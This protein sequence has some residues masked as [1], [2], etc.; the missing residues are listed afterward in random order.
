MKFSTIL[1]LSTLLLAAA[2][3]GAKLPKPGKTSVKAPKPTSSKK[4][5]TSVK[6]TA[7]PTG[8]AKT[9]GAAK[10]TTAC[11]ASGTK[12]CPAKTTGAAK[13]STTCVASGTKK[14][15]AATGKPTASACPRLPPK[16]SNGKK[17]KSR[18]TKRAITASRAY[19]CGPPGT[20][21]RGRSPVAY[22][23]AYINLSITTGLAALSDKIRAQ[24]LKAMCGAD[25]SNTAARDIDF[26]M[27]KVFGNHEKL[28]MGT[29]V[30]GNMFEYPLMDNQATV[31][32]YNGL[33]WQTAT[34]VNSNAKQLADR[35]IFNSAGD[36]CG[37]TT[38]R[39]NV[40]AAGN[41]VFPC[42]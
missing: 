39:T 23:A 15:P 35:V 25:L 12:K 13:P 27:P 42:T 29:C 7:K 5:A 41:G 18:V 20:D 37:L 2:V 21:T 28:A 14:C 32:G 30:V 34:V 36:F 40:A 11:V 1:T 19:T 6:A 24:E 9:T 4:A 38:H 8:P 31:F 3:E 16:P 33:N 22:T 17:P 10:P 26:L